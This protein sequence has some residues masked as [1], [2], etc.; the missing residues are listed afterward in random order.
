MSKTAAKD[1]TQI[2]MRD[3]A[4]MAGVSESTVSRALAGSQLVAEHTRLRILELA[5]S[6]KYAVNEH[7]RNLALGQTRTIEVLFPI[8]RGT[9]QRVSDPF[10]VDMVAE[11]IDALSTHDYDVLLSTSPPW[12][13]VRPGCAFLG[14]RADGVIFVGQGRHREEIAEFARDNRIVVTWG[15]GGR[16]DEG[17][18]IGTDNVRGGYLA[19]RHLIALGRRQIAFLGDCTLPEIEERYEGYC[20][21][22]REAGMEP[23]D[24]LRINAPFDIDGARTVT[25]G[26]DRFGRHFD[27]IFAASD[28]I[29]MAAMANL[30]AA[31]AR[32]PDDVAVVGFDDVAMAAH[33]HPALT[34]VRQNIA[35]GAQL[36]TAKIMAMLQGE[37]PKGE[38]LPAK[39]IIRDS[40][41]A[42][43]SMRQESGDQT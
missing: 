13:E 30:Q 2:T 21:A 23:G 28:M 22:L 12:S 18:V 29:A 9:L 32:I 8:E 38:M 43:L 42:P 33:M 16:R 24:A 17:C 5:R 11:L 14:G 7:A 15:A 26:L 20:A 41:G 37:K 3:I 34:T 39:L 4:R 1:R 19:A 10:F 27:A 35:E 31:G 25:V 40:C 36:M 6:T